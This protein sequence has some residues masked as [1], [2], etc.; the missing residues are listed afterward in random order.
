MRVF[1]LISSREAFAENPHLHGKALVAALLISN[2]IRQ[3]AEFVLYLADEGAAVKVS[4]ASVRSLFPDEE[5]SAGLLRK[6][7]RG[8]RHPG[9]R[10]IRGVGLRDFLTRRPVVDGGNGACKPGDEFT[11]VAS[12]ADAADYEADCGTGWGTLPPHHQ[13]AIANIEG[14]R[15]MADPPP[16]S[17]YKEP[18]DLRRGSN[19]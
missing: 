11:Y 3:D 7:M 15:R 4:G 18:G 13:F 16:L 9:A 10:L 12:L 17:I 1:V 6:V 19:K 2:G 5:S 14:D 8:S